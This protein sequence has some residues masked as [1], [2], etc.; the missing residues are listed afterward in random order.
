[1]VVEFLGLFSLLPLYHCNMVRKNS[2]G[3]I[4][5]LFLSNVDVVLILVPVDA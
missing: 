2:Q 4:Y 3:L 5:A 1:M